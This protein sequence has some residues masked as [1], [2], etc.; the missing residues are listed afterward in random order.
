MQQEEK[1]LLA[2][3]SEREIGPRLISRLLKYFHHD[4]A[5]VWKSSD[6]EL[7]KAGLGE[8]QRNMV[9][10]VI[11]TVNP[12]EEAKKLVQLEI[13]A[14][15]ILSK[16]YPFL[17]KEI[18]DPPAVLYYKGVLPS[19]EDV[20]LAIVGSRACS[21]YGR[22]VTEDIVF[23]LA[24][25]GIVVVSGLALG[26][27]GLAHKAALRAGGKT[28]AVLACGLDSVYPPS[29]RQMAEEIQ[30]KGG[31]IISEN[32]PGTP[33]LPFFFPLRNRIISGLSR[34][35]L[36]IE[37]AAR[38]GALITARYAL[39]QNREVFAV[40]GSIYHSRCEGTNQLIK[41]G[42]YPVTNI[43]DILS[44]MNIK[45]TLF[46]KIFSYNKQGYNNEEEIL[47]SLIENEPRF[48]DD[49]VRQSHLDVAVVNATLMM[50]EIK[51]V[52]KNVGGGYYLRCKQSED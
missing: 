5:A 17:L 12:E 8:K 1:Y 2:L 37:A 16:D 50:L 33:P 19:K 36:V 18:P 44:Q 7:K 27:D 24:K 30:Q 25:L 31:A 14:T 3:N 51:G 38:S 6:E 39:E 40:P 52:V 4:I 26:I 9:K 29:H 23:Q 48:V 21:A 42:A 13:K 11:A 47:L 46:G 43:E 20:L 41:M 10:K 28:L 15:T 32:P 22:Q 45:R 34:A 35:T 49:L